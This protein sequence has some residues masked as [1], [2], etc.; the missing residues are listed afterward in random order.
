MVTESYIITVSFVIIVVG[1]G[2]IRVADDVLS[3]VYVVMHP[4]PWFETTT[5]LLRTY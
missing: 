3:L 1:C 4:S 2:V 5:S